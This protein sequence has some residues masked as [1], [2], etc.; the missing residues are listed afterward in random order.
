MTAT[1]TIDPS[2]SISLP[3]VFLQKF[4]LKPGAKLIADV[5]DQGIELRPDDGMSSGEAKL[6]ERDGFLVFTGTEPFDAVEAI[7][8]ARAERDGELFVQSKQ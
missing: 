2:G 6:V 8:A 7:L 3:K 4:Q 1:L 5:N